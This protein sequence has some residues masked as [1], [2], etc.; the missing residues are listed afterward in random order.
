M[1]IIILTWHA[2]NDAKTCKICAA[3]NGYTWVFDTSKGDVMT[4]ALWHPIYGIVW[5]LSQGSNAHASGYL[6]GHTYNCRCKIDHKIDAEDI[7]AK[8]VYLKE[9]L[10]ETMS[11]ISDTESG[12]YRKTTFEDIGID[13]SKYGVH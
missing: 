11:E 8:C 12:S 7:L 4:D 2:H 13:P 10:E 1:A 9:F 3:I 6:S 5:S